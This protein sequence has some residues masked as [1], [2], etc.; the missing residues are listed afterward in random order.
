[1]LTP[2]F[3][4]QLFKTSPTTIRLTNI[5]AEQAREELVKNN[6]GAQEPTPVKGVFFNQLF[7]TALEKK[8]DLQ[9]EAVQNYMLSAFDSG[10]SFVM[11][12]YFG[13]RI[14]FDAPELPADANFQWSLVEV[15]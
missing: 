15:L 13:P 5:T 3:A 2:F 8:L 14:D 7:H 12:Q 6:K 1:M 9:F 11:Y 4:P 10:D